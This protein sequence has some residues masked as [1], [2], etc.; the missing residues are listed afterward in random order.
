[1][2]ICFAMTDRATVPN[3]TICV[4]DI[5]DAHA[6]PYVQATTSSVLSGSSTSTAHSPDITPTNPGGVIAATCSIG[7]GPWTSISSPTG[8]HF[9]CVT[10]SGETDLDT[11]NN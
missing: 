3:T 7:I 10:Y 4:Y 1:M 2:T 8:A 9:M 5:I 11:F 6:T